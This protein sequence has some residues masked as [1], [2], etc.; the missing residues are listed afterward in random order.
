M[1]PFYDGW[2]ADQQR[3]LDSLRPLTLEQMQLRPAPG[4][5]AIWQL[6]SNMAGGRYY[7]FCRMLGEDDKGARRLFQEGDWE[8]RPD[9]PK[10][11]A[12]LEIAFLKTWDAVSAAM[13]RWTLEDL[14]TPVTATDFWGR[15]QTITPAWVLYRVIAHEAHHGA[16]ISSILRVHGLPT[17]LNY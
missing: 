11:A 13:D 2:A 15:E 17:L 10:S 9:N 7:W 3:L 16:E 5:Y 12:E 4:E 6:A 14:Q 8:D 1:Q